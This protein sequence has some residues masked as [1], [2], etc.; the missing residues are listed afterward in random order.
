[1]RQK[2]CATWLFPS[3]DDGD[4]LTGSA[5]TTRCLSGTGEDAW[6]LHAR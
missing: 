6:P 3:S 2:G 5:V 4:K 1:M